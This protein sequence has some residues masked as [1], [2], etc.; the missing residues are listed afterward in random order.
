[1]FPEIYAENS[2]PENAD[3]FREDYLGLGAA[4]HG[5]GMDLL[6]V[7]NVQVLKGPQGTLFGRNTTAGAV[8]LETNVDDVSPETYLDW[9]LSRDV[10]REQAESISLMYQWGREGKLDWTTNEVETI[11]GR[12]PRRLEEFAREIAGPVLRERYGGARE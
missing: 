10:E 3:Q 1:M 8:L 5:V 9:M 7:R 6:D 12:A 2:W 4:V 11:T